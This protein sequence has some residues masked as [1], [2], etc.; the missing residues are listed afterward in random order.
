MSVINCLLHTFSIL[1]L[2]GVFR[3]CF[4]VCIQSYCPAISNTG[5]KW[6]TTRCALRLLCYQGLILLCCK[7]SL[8]YHRIHPE[9]W[10]DRMLRVRALGLNTISVCT[11][12]SLSNPILHKC[13]RQLAH[14]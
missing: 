1:L 4:E 9:Q 3:V 10:E 2:R 11:P 12:R 14:A 5:F 13:S 6:L 7:R 8:H